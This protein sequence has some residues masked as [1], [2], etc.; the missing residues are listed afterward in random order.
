[1]LGHRGKGKSALAWWLANKLHSKGKGVICLGM[2]RRSRRYFPKWVNYLSDYRKLQTCREQLIVVDEAAF[3]VSARSHQSS[4]NIAWLRLVAVCRHSQHLLFF[5]VQSN[6]SL[7]VGLVSEADLV[8]F[9]QP[10]ILHKRFSRPELREDV[11]QAYEELIK[12]KGKTWT[13]VKEYL[14]GGV[15]MLRSHLPPWWSEAASEAFTLVQLEEHTQ[16]RKGAGAQPNHGKK[17]RV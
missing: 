7:D 16:D 14:N 17:R 10:S 8:C 9:K 4:E 1:M 12:R 15:G 2:P 13:F 5:I 11:E 3:Q 6:R